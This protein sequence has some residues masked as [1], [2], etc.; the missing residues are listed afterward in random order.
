MIQSNGDQA[1]HCYCLPLTRKQKYSVQLALGRGENIITVMDTRVRTS[2]AEVDRRRDVQTGWT[3]ALVNTLD[4]ARR[5][6]R[7]AATARYKPVRSDCSLRF[8]Q[9]VRPRNS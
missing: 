7:R 1:A 6:R 3:I 5:P 4:D 9:T 2:H 8:A